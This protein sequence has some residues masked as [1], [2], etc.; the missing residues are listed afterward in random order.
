MIFLSVIK[1]ELVVTD[2]LN[3]IP[4][5]VFK[6]VEWT[7]FFG[8]CLISFLFM[9]EVLEKYLSKDTSFKQYE[10]PI[11]EHPTI[12]ICLNAYTSKKKMY[13]GKDF[14]ISYHYL[15]AN[16]QFDSGY[17]RLH[18]NMGNNYSNTTKEIIQLDRI[19]SLY[20]RLP[21][22][23]ISTYAKTE[24]NVI[25]TGVFRRI[26]VNFNESMSHMDL[27]SL[28]TYITSEK[29]SYG[30]IGNK[31]MDGKVMTLTLNKNMYYEIRLKVEKIIY[32]KTKSQC[33]DEV[34]FYKCYG[35]ILL[36]V[37]SEL[38]KSHCIPYF[39]SFMN[40]YHEHNIT[41]CNSNL[42]ANNFL[43]SLCTQAV[44]FGLFHQPSLKET[45]RRSCTTYSYSGIITQAYESLT[46]K[47]ELQYEFEYPESVTV[48][49]EYMIYDTIGMIGSV[50][51]TLGMFLGFSFTS[52]IS[53]VISYFQRLKI[54]PGRICKLFRRRA[55]PQLFKAAD[56][57]HKPD[58]QSKTQFNQ[59]QNQVNQLKNN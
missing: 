49:E 43:S 19:Y 16:H 5:R 20:V 36:K 17:H 7:L 10:E 28:K 13:F 54:E 25:E 57:H 12:T 41:M 45:C 52:V 34:P 23:K 4:N 27:P 55:R 40:L 26:T 29:N 14:N 47:I 22:Y 50:G 33:I 6:T 48:S 11:S 15:F 24:S 18:L 32:L 58:N 56:E 9:R 31:W 59:S 51:G 8:L 37:I 42:Y 38:C 2:M 46:D 3:I 44:A 1:H 30:V 53:L 39:L 35:E 21:C